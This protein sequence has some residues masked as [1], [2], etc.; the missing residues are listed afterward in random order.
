VDRLSAQ[1]AEAERR[2]GGLHTANP[3][4]A[5]PS[6]F[7]ADILKQQAQRFV[8]AVGSIVQRR[9]GTNASANAKGAAP[10][11]IILAIDNLDMVSVS[12]AREIL[13]HARCLL[14]PGYASLI[15]LNPAR[16]TTGPDADAL[17]LDKWIGA[18]FQV[19]EACAGRDCSAQIRDLLGDGAGFDAGGAK[20][21]VAVIDATR[22][23]LDE[24]LSESETALLTALAPLAGNSARAVKHFVNLYRL[25][26]A[27]WADAPEERGTLALMLALDAG[28]SPEDLASVNAAL[29]LSPAGDVVFD[30]YKVGPR[31]ASALV[32]LGSAQA[33]LTAESLRRAGAA[34]RLFSFRPLSS[35]ATVARS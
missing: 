17:N 12:R 22:S 10:Q 2:A 8:A 30:H 35:G 13:T 9:S 34:A 18:P 27:Q 21:P 28:G 14:G 5:D 7:A 32:T 4:L 16:L 25:L 31:L 26:R 29:A 11:R 15:A 33:R 19:G 1:A 24:P 3:A 6:P 20:A 23:T